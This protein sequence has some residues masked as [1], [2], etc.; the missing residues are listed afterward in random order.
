MG[1]KMEKLDRDLL[2]QVKRGFVQMPAEAGPGPVAGG[3]ILTQAQAAPMGGDP[4]QQGAPA[5]GMP[6]DPSMAGGAPIGPNMAGGAPAADPSQMSGAPAD[7]GGGGGIPPELMAALS[8]A[9][10]GGGSSTSQ[11][12]MTVPDLIQLIQALQAGGGSKPKSKP[13]GESGG[14]AG[15]SD[16]KLDQILQ[17]LGGNMT[18][19]ATPSPAG[20]PAQQ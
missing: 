8:G 19:Q 17:I 1:A 12:T 9:G 5:G 7:V 20:A 10:A 11:I 18:G 16:A 14:A 6:M 2:S 4:S 3:G 15:G 13:A